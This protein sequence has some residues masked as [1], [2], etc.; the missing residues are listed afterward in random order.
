MENVAKDEGMEEMDLNKSTLSQQ[1]YQ[2]LR[3]DI[4]TG[5]IAMG[6]KLTLKMLQERFGVS[7]TPIREALARLAEDELAIYYSNV[8]VNVI[9][10]TE[11]DLRELYSF[12]GDLDALAI[13]YASRSAQNGELCRKLEE[14]VAFTGSMIE[15]PDPTEEEVSRWI[16]SSDNFHLLF[17]QYC[18]NSRLVR[19][20]QKLRSQLTIFSFR[21]ET[22]LEVQRSIDACHHDIFAA[23]E[24]GDIPGAERLM[25]GHLQQSLLYAIDMLK[26]ELG[27]EDK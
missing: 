25:S 11:Q 23:Y 9:S 12:M 13:R 17:Y 3:A 18:G 1:I 7:S 6:Q 21:Y 24:A 10:L 4:I 27:R 19:A 2:I 16:R 20:A 14:N 22:D 15:R 26:K 8:G 5:R